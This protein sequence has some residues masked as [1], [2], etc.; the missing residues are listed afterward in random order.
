MARIEKDN[1]SRAK[2]AASRAVDGGSNPSEPIPT[3]CYRKENVY[4]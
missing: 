4:K 1:F 3:K 2:I